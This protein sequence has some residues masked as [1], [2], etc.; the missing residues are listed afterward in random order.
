[1][2]DERKGNM[3]Y[4]DIHVTYDNA[5]DG[6]GYSIFVKANTSNED[7]VL[8]YAIDNHL[9]EE[10]GDEK[11]VDYIEEINEKD[12]CNVIGG[13]NGNLL[14]SDN[15]IIPML[16]DTLLEV[17]TPDDNLQLWWKNEDFLSEISDLLEECK[18]ELC[19]WWNDDFFLRKK[20][21]CWWANILL[22]ENK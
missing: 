7:K 12:Y 8:Q 15:E 21:V 5:K 20:G 11:Y 14:E 19:L 10:D 2:P 22:F 6:A 16:D 13:W 17:N 1:M 3:K 18:R 4:F 9:L